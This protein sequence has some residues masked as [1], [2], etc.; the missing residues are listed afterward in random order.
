MAVKSIMLVT[1]ISALL[2]ESCKYGNLVAHGLN[3][4]EYYPETRDFCASVHVISYMHNAC[5]NCRII[6]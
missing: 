4:S 1:V 2:V 3:T 6:W 5:S